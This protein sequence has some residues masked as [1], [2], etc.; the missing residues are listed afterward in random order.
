MTVIFGIGL[1]I[2]LAFESAWVLASEPKLRRPAWD[3]HDPKLWGLGSV[4]IVTS[5]PDFLGFAWGL[6]DAV[7]NLEFRRVSSYF[8]KVG[9]SRVAW[10][11]NL[12][13]GIWDLGLPLGHGE[14]GFGI[15]DLGFGIRDMV[16]RSG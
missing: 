7:K 2:R 3:L 11:W 10:S 16:S 1:E 13:F 8:V 6:L 14:L 12:G 9:V 5:A 4:Q 15:W